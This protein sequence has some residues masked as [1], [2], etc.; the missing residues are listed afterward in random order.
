MEILNFQWHLC[1]ILSQKYGENKANKMLSV[2]GLSYDKL[3]PY[4]YTKKM[5][6]VDHV[7]DVSIDPNANVGNDKLATKLMIEPYKPFHKLVGFKFLYDKMMDLYGKARADELMTSLLDGSLYCHD[8][9]RI[10]NGYCSAFATRVLLEEGRRYGRLWSKPPK[11]PRS[12]MGQVIET[13]MNLSQEQSG[14]LALLDIFPCYTAILVRYYSERNNLNFNDAVY[15]LGR[16]IKT[17]VKMRKEIE[18]DFQSMIHV[19][20]NNFRINSDPPFTN[21]T[22]LDEPLLKGMME[23][24][25][26]WLLLEK[27]GANINDDLKEGF[28]KLVK[29][30]QLIFAEFMSKGD[31]ITGAFYTFPVTTVSITIDDNGSIVDSRYIRKLMKF[32]TKGIFNIYHSYGLDSVKF[33]MCCFHPKQKVLIRSPL[34]GIELVEIGE[35]LNRPAIEDG[36]FEVYHAGRWVSAKP[37]KVPYNRKWYKIKTSNNKEIVVT[38]DHIHA[39]LGG[40]KRTVDLKEGDYILFSTYYRHGFEDGEFGI[41]SFLEGFVIGLF[42]GSGSFKDCDTVLFSLNRCYLWKFVSVIEEVVMRFDPS[43]E[44]DIFDGWYDGVI[45][46]VYSKVFADFIKKFVCVSQDYENFPILDAVLRTKVVFMLGLISGLEV[47]TGGNPNQICSTSKQLIENLEVIFTFAGIPTFIDVSINE[48]EFVYCIRSCEVEDWCY[49]DKNGD[50][51]FKIVSIEEID[52]NEGVA[53]CFEIQ[54]GEPYFT[55]PNGI[56]THNCRLQMDYTL[57]RGIDSFGMGVFT[58]IG[59]LRVVSINLPRIGYLSKHYSDSLEGAIAIFRQKIKDA[60][61]VLYAHR[62]LLEDI[63]KAGYLLPFQLGWYNFKNF[64][65]TF[66]FIGIAEMINAIAPLALEDEDKYLE[67]IEIILDVFNEEVTRF[68]KEDKV[69]YNIEQVPGESLAATFYQLD[70]IYFDKQ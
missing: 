37:V 16:I 64:F 51:Y 53:Y 12:Y 70:K 38:D 48:G 67:Y 45:I 28:I 26:Y 22:V 24:A 11:K 54:D 5:L 66:G 14:A 2:H 50:V 44:I 32:N 3:D 39:T 65:S 31:P 29:E 60:R 27:Y 43:A 4:W 36:G 59:S 63:I 25:G 13:V 69:P 10:L 18:D 46:Q 52:N 56:I 47:I 58:P 1:R 68:I 40:D 19:F 7:A 15:K 57:M 61:D 20:H 49:F 6:F 30:I 8:S 33:N 34:T 42:L 23:E 9:T 55:L 62:K 35:F 17:N 21:V 41:Y